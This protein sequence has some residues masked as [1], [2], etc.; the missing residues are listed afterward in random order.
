MG[1]YACSV[2]WVGIDYRAEDDLNLTQGQSETLDAKGRQIFGDANEPFEETGYANPIIVNGDETMGLGVIVARFHWDEIHEV[3]LGQL[4][5][6]VEDIKEKLQKLF[7]E[8]DI[9]VEPKVYH[10]VDFDG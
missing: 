3:G 2:F 4:N 6:Q 7:R 8:V 5:K 1:T 10:H 9:L